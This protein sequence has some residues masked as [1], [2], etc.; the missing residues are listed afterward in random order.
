MDQNKQV[1]MWCE[2]GWQKQA[3]CGCSACQ[4]LLFHFSDQTFSFSCSGSL[5]LSIPSAPVEDMFSCHGNCKKSTFL[6]LQA[7][8]RTKTGKLH[9]LETTHR[10]EMAIKRYFLLRK[11]SACL[12]RCLLGMQSMSPAHQLANFGKAKAKFKC[13]GSLTLNQH[14]L[15]LDQWSTR[16]E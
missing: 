11:Q 10:I 16:Q 15:T 4:D 12:V 6:L 8:R 9:E 3:I 13:H 2:Q 1:I 5:C 7:K 14:M